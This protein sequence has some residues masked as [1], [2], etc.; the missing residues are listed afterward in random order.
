MAPAAFSIRAFPP[1]AWISPAHWCSISIAWKTRL[2]PTLPTRPARFRHGAIGCRLLCLWVRSAITNEESFLFLV[3]IFLFSV[4]SFW[5]L[6]FTFSLPYRQESVVLPFPFYFSP[7]LD[8][9]LIPTQPAPKVFACAFVL[10]LPAECR[11]IEMSLK[12]DSPSSNLYPTNN[13]SPARE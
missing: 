11:R 5:F 3:P 2:V 1:T 7:L 6:I 10:K 4:L 9:P 8:D 13:D 12:M